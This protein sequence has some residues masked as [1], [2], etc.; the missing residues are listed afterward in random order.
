MHQFIHIP[1][2]GGCAVG[3]FLRLN[4]P[5]SFQEMGHEFMVPSSENPIVVVRSPLDR[6]FSVFYFWTGGSEIYSPKDFFGDEDMSF[7]NFID[8]AQVIADSI[9][10]TDQLVANYSRVLHV[11]PQSRWLSPENYAKTIV[12]RYN[13]DM[14]QSLK[15]LVEYLKL[16]NFSGMPKVNISKKKPI[17]FSKYENG[18]LF[19]LYK[20]DFELWNDINHHQYKFKKVF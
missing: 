2:T 7:R 12:I 9:P 10:H 4:Y 18:K 5:G 11:L 3:G 15:K 17:T 20:S 8:S 14:T 6:V 1:K 16:P 13:R 19:E